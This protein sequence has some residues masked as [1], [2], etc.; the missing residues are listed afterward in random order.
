MIEVIA[1]GGNIVPHIHLP[2]QSGNNAVLKIMGRKYT[3]ESYLDLVD[4]IKTQIPNV[5]LTTDII[6]GY[7][8][9]TEAQFEETLTLYDEVEF[10]TRILIFIHKGMVH[11]LLKCK[12]MYRWM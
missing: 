4:R 7:P 2:V 12:I 10:E 5:A 9:E 3:R 11:Q 1:N 6:V 8:N